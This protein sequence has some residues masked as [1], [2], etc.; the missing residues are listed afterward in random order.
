MVEIRSITSDDL[1]V[2]ARCLARGFGRDPDTDPAARDRFGATVEFDRTFAAFDGED[3]VGTAGALT[4]ELTVPGGVGVSMGG[5]TRVSVLP[6][7]RRRGVMRSLMVRHLEEV[8]E[9]GDPLAGLWASESSIYERF[10]FGPATHKYHAGMMSSRAAFREPVTPGGVRLAELDEAEKIIRGLYETARQSTPGMLSRSNAWWQFRVLADVEAWR[11]GKSAIRYAIYES[12]GEP[13]GYARYRQKAKWDD[14]AGDG[15]VSVEEVITTDMESHRALWSYLT[16]IDLFPNIDYWN[17]PVDDPLPTS[18]RASR[19][20][21]LK[22]GDALWVRLID[23][24]RALE[25]RTY[26]LDGAVTFGIDDP[27]FPDAGGVFEL[28]VDG[29]SGSCRRV[30]GSPDITVSADALGRLYLG[31]GDA[32]QLAR[33]GRITGDATWVTKLQRLF[34]G[35]TQPWCNEVF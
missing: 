1:D 18:L 29:G 17:L 28:V 24:C 9:H 34:R 21:N 12:A 35:D 26:G 16:N 15:E 4:L 22:L 7:H 30:D 33:T 31:G 14:Y 5:T 19:G 3:V 32:A 6:T 11:G 25:A 23:V 10:G 27:I 13:S 20:V 8:R 2:F